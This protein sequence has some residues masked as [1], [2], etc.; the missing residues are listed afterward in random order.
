MPP[1]FS[2]QDFQEDGDDND[3]EDYESLLSECG[4][5][6]SSFSLKW[7][8]RSR[9][10]SLIA[11][12]NKAFYDFD[13]VT[14]PNPIKNEN[15]G[16]HFHY[17][18]NG[19]YESGKSVNLNEAKEIAKLA[20]H[21][22][23]SSQSSLG[24]VA[25]N[26]KQ[27]EAIRTEIDT[28]SMDYQELS[29]FRE[30]DDRFLISNL[31]SV[32]GEERD[33]IIISLCFGR[34]REGRLSQNFGW[35]NRRGGERRLNVAITRARQKLIFV[36]SIRSSDLK[37]SGRS[38]EQ[39]KK[40]QAY[41]AY[42]ER[43]GDLG[44]ETREISQPAEDCPIVEDICSVLEKEGYFTKRSIGQ[45][46]FPI[47]IAVSLHQDSEEYLLGIECDGK[48]YEKY[49]TARDRDRLRRQVLENELGWN[50]YRIWTKEWFENK[51][52]QINRLLSYLKGLEDEDK[53]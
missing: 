39:V 9:D 53:N 36:S 12:S 38:E 26:K 17:V 35:L 50:I 43:K 48:T 42:A 28:L 4:K 11:F 44:D 10:E 33:V 8:Y 2:F 19:V 24:I 40:L 41:L 27:A 45:S 15:R 3:A 21:H 52:E 34:N 7:H 23:Q 5:F 29:V 30:E 49:R 13:L 31:E 37:P 47:D 22:I 14:F 51:Q 1:T 46:K 20:L 6:M 18:D 16:V 32:Q 25:F